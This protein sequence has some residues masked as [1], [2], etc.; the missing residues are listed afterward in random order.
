[1]AHARAESG[2]RVITPTW[3][4]RDRAYAYLYAIAFVIAAFVGVAAYGQ[5]SSGQ[6]NPTGCG[7]TSTTGGHLR[8][9]CPTV[10]SITNAVLDP[11]VNDSIGGFVVNAGQTSAVLT[12]GTAF[13][14]PPWCIV[15]GNTT[16][17]DPTYVVSTTAITMSSLTASD[18]YTWFCVAQPQS[19]PNG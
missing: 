17:T 5:G 12:F 10:P 7:F 4:S 2:D 11:P 3:E 19:S 18:R 6:N 13:G 16:G 15:K 14:L 8:V 1:M 9:S